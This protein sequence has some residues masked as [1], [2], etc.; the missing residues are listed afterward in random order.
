MTTRVIRDLFFCGGEIFQ[1]SPRSCF[2]DIAVAILNRL[3]TKNGKPECEAVEAAIH[4][5]APHPRTPDVVS[6]PQGNVST[7]FLAPLLFQN[8][9]ID[10]ARR[11]TVD[12]CS[13]SSREDAKNRDS[14]SVISAMSAI[15][16]L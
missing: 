3:L 5:V 10:L 1:I 16:G 11:A 9:G 14:G 2:S 12:L 7:F 4:N 6:R 13:R 8:S 15:L